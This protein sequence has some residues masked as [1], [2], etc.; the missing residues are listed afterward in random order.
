MAQKGRLAFEYRSF[1]D[2]LTV[3]LLEK[4]LVLESFLFLLELGMCLHEVILGP[5]LDWTLLPSEAAEREE[6]IAIRV[7][8]VRYDLETERNRKSNRDAISLRHNTFSKIISDRQTGRRNG[9]VFALATSRVGM[10]CKQ[11]IR[12]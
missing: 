5:P 3:P 8:R 6:P 10:F 12:Y 2:E 7:A 9:D 4:M 11:E 1:I